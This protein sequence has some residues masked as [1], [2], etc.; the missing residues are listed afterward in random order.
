MANR[1]KMAKVNAVLTLHAQGWSNRRIARTLGIDRKTVSEHLRGARGTRTEAPLGSLAGEDDSKRAIAPTGLEPT[2]GGPGAAPLEPSSGGAGSSSND[3]DSGEK[4]TGCGAAEVSAGGSREASVGSRS[5]CARFRA[6]IEAKLE[7][8][9]SAQRIHQDLVADH[10]FRGRYWSVRRFVAR[11]ESRRPLPF[12]RMEVGPG[13]EAQVDFGMGAPIVSSEGRR[14]RCYVLR[15]VLSHSRK[16]YSVVVERQT[17]EDFV[18]ALE[19]AFQ[20]FGGVPKTLV[21]DNLRAAVKRADWFEPE[22]NP[23]VRAFAAHYGVAI[24]PTKPYLPRHKGKVERGIDY[25]Q[26]NALK[27]RTFASLEEQNAYLQRWEETVADKRLHGTTRQQVGR[28]FQEV[29]RGTLS[30]LPSTRFPFFEE[31]RRRVHRDGHVEVAKAY[32]SVP[33]EYLGEEVWARWDSHTV[34]IFNPRWEQIA[35]HA[36]QHPGRFSTHPEHLAAEKI[37]GVE[38][39]AEWLLKKVRVIGPQ[40]TRWAEA[41]IAHRGVEGVRVLQGLRALTQKYRSEQ[42]EAAC[43]SAWR[44]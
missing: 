22:L 24:L 15:V 39:G 10:G 11:L 16:A 5:E 42:L 14:Q 33:P 44:H 25:V 18:R 31:G 26:E 21:I 43:E 7:A 32:Y 4:A 17:T 12:R 9:L 1:L 41:M 27:G 35:L 30:P 8:G 40:T 34:R 23:K 38:R 20:A 2:A 36:R 19:S 37:S 3:L 29:E 28:Q 13:E 6:I